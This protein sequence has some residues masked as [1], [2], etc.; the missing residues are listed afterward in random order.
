MRV[1]QLEERVG[2][3]LAPGAHLGRFHIV[4]PLGAGGMGAVFLAHDSVLDVYVALKVLHAEIADRSS[5]ERLLATTYDSD[6]CA[7]R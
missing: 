3:K 4:R 7:Q 2:G 6:A 5:H 1:T